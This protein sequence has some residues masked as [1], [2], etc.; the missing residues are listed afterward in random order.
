M[1]C[2]IV[3]KRS[4]SMQLKL[5]FPGVPQP[6]AQVWEALDEETRRAV[7]ERL[8]ELMASATRAGPGAEGCNHE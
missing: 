3:L 2:S 4:T 8:A 6:H 1:L 5:I 7:L